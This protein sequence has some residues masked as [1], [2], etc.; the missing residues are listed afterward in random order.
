MPE[1]NTLIIIIAAG[2]AADQESAN[3]R[4]NSTLAE[5]PD[6]HDCGIIDNVH[7]I[8]TPYQLQDMFNYLAAYVDIHDKLIVA[9][10]AGRWA[11]QNATTPDECGRLSNIGSPI[12]EPMINEIKPVYTSPKG[13]LRGITFSDFHEREKSAWEE[14]PPELKA[15]AE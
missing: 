1:Q 4:L 6:V 14:P 15:T 11:C 13:R 2:D 5:L 8:Q 3:E 9:P 10:L 12:S 7:I